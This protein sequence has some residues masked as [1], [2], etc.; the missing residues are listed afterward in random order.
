MTAEETALTQRQQTASDRQSSGQ[1][2]V[3]TWGTGRGRR[4]LSVLSIRNYRLF[5]LGQVVSVSGTWMQRVAQSWLVL[6]ITNSGTA[7]GAVTAL[8]AAPVLILG[9][10]GGSL[11]DRLDKRRLLM[12]TQIAAGTLAV[13]LAILVL[14]DRVELWMIYGFALLLGVSSSVDSPARQAFVMEMVGRD[15]LTNALGL[16]SVLVNVARMIGP[17][18][19][20]LLIVAAG[21]GLCFL[22]NGLS[23]LALIV[24]LLLMDT[25]QLE[26]GDTRDSKERRMRAAFAYVRGTRELMVPLLMVVVISI[27]VY[28]FEVILPLLARFTF[29]G[30]AGTFGTMFGAIGV[31]ALIGG[32]HTASRSRSPDDSLAAAAILLCVGMAA[33]TFAP[34]LIFAL[35]ALV[36]VGA[37]GTG[38]L[39]L[40]NS[41]LQLKSPTESRGFVVGLWAVAFLGSRPFGAL[42]IGYVGENA[43]PRYGI[44]IGAVAAAVVAVWALRVYRPASSIQSKHV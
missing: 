10:F 14:T 7:V 30:D 12:V 35:I 13:G 4:I 42:L 8:Q 25:S 32:L 11:A 27:F 33:T 28:E 2:Q 36:L 31:G 24:A 41:S 20:G 9:T 43:G 40:A 5:F 18:I 38:F 6:E 29:G 34:T 22:F 16:N 19:A 39:A 26:K 1:H 17:A 37:A 23:Y 44:G 15:K 3:V 21:I